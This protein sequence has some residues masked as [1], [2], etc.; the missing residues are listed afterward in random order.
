MS[1]SHKRSGAVQKPRA[2]ALNVQQVRSDALPSRVDVVIIGGGI[3]GVSSALFLAQ[4]GVSVALL[5]KG[6][7]AAEQSSR[8]WGWCR[9]TMRDPAE[10][11][12]VMESLRL[13]RDRAK[14]GGADTGFRTTG[15]LFL[16]GRVAGDEQT[17]RQWLDRV[18]AHGLDSRM[19]SGAEVN[20]LLPGLRQSAPG[21]LYTPSDGGAEP[22]RAAPEIAEA[23]RRAGAVI[24]TSCAVRGLARQAGRVSGVVTE[25]GEVACAA[26]LVAAGAWTRLFCGPLGIDLPQ[27]KLR[28][29]V[30]RTAP[31][32][33]GP[34]ASALGDGFGYRKR[35]DG[36]YTVSQSDGAV[37]DLVPDGFRLFR[38]FF[39]TYLREKGERP[40]LRL[41]QR[42]WQE[43]RTPRRWALEAISPF[44][45]ARVLDPE[46]SAAAIRQTII[47]LTA[48]YPVFKGM[49]VV[50]TW[51]GMIDVTPDALPVISAIDAIPGLF[52]ATG[53]SGHG[54]GIGPGAGKLAAELVSGDQ[55]SV[56]P[57]PFRYAR[58]SA[59]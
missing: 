58:F 36:G 15:I 6:A 47:K 7:I 3:I 33:G 11:P 12:L 51:A 31:L 50:A 56:D 23:A 26:V 39:P 10:I 38:Q 44:E 46:P 49:R 25:R 30:F 2:P 24:V 53:F 42:F 43:W 14:L 37:F 16:N 40:N 45:Q 34:D 4:K 20:S 35:E 57:R 13:W 59:G 27:L 17:H 5:E 22:E 9:A 8:N 55:P 32:T 52:I 28:G 54:F 19:L 1:A 18:R 48:A 41:G 21:A 29:S